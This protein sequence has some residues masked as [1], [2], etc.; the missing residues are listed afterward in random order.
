MLE[1]YYVK[2]TN[3]GNYKL[4]NF[5]FLHLKSPRKFAQVQLGRRAVGDLTKP[6]WGFLHAKKNSLE[7]NYRLV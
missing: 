4:M 7:S 6:N 1:L 3:M 5:D 2:L